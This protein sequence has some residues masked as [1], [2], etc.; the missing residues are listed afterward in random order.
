MLQSTTRMFGL[1]IPTKI[2][3]LHCAS[4]TKRVLYMFVVE[5]PDLKDKPAMKSE[6]LELLRI[7]TLR[8]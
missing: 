7:R 4:F 5:S 1:A 6:I 2:Y 8:A 3:K